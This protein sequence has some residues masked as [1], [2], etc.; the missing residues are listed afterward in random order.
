MRY[1]VVQWGAGRNGAALIRAIARHPDLELAGCKVYSAD[2]DGVDAGILAGIAPLD[3]R[4]TA[5]RQ[6]IIDIP[7]DVVIHCP[8]LS[9]DMRENDRDICDLLR[10]GRN[11]ISVSGAH[12]M[13]AAIPGYAAQFEAACRAGGSTF[14]AAGVNPGFIC[15]R[16]APTLTGL[17]V[18]VD[19]I[20]IRETYDCSNGTPDLLFRAMGFGQPPDRWTAD[21][22]LGAMFNHLF[23]QLIHNMAATLGVGLREVRHSAQTAPAH[24]D[25]AVAGGVVAAGTVAAIGQSWEGVPLDPGQIRL[26]KQTRWVIATDIPGWPPHSGWQIEIAGIPGLRAD[27]RIDPEG[28]HTYEPECMVGGAI[29]M[30]PEVV[31]APPGLLMPRIFAPFRKHFA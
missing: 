29:P 13:P 16:L 25:I 18:D 30:I 14:A 15:E 19:R 1:R 8:R 23:V 5:D 2:K 27:I 21:S 4:A 6:A 3:V 26:V 11:V 28:D 20:C 17:C 31:A 7:A 9:P 10:A 12:S 22:P 24:R